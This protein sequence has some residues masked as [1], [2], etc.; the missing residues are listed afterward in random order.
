MSENSNR[1][2]RTISGR[3]LVVTMFTFGVLATAVL[4]IYWTVRMTPF[5]PLQQAL[6]REFP[7]SKPYASGGTLRKS[8]ES[9][10]LVVLRTDFDPRR[11][12]KDTRT[13]IKSRLDRLRSLANALGDLVNYDVLA[14]H[15]YQPQE[16]HMISQKTFFRQVDTWEERDSAELVGRMARP[17]RKPSTNGTLPAP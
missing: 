7:K 2:L 6:E 14:L 11:D 4:W 8:D 3:S 10:L 15:L 13:K 17:F 12:S 9:V 5:M 16:E 1:S